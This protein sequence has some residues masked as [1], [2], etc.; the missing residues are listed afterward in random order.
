MLRLGKLGKKKSAAWH[1]EVAGPALLTLSQQVVAVAGRLSISPNSKAGETLAINLMTLSQELAQS[2]GDPEIILGVTAR[3]D[4]VL[5][6]FG[7]WQCE[8]V[9]DT[10]T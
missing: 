2:G 9:A 7:E 8:Y 3:L 4:L 1:M 10:I 6:K 5:T